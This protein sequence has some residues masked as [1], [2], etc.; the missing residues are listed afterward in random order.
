MAKI[1][2]YS[3]QTCPYCLMAKHFLRQ[4]K[5]KFEDINVSKDHKAAEKMVRKSGQYGVPVIEIDGK[6]I[7]G[8]D[9][10]AIKKALKL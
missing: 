4:H 3:T 7:I 5:I 6:I 8:F 9:R 1:K 2:M 10:E